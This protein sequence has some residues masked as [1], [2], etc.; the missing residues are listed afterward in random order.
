[1]C[2]CLMLFLHSVTSLHAKLICKSN[3]RKHK[4][5]KIRPPY[6]ILKFH[7]T[8]IQQLFFLALAP[9]EW[10]RRWS[11]KPEILGLIPGWAH[12]SFSLYYM[13][14]DKPAEI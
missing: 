4:K 6:P 2:L 11:R 3:T 8:P 12:F 9:I 1:M 5:K 14:D 10:L 13:T 7:V